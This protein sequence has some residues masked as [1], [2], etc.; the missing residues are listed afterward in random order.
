MAAGFV[1]VDEFVGIGVGI[2]ISIRRPGFMFRAQIWPRCKSI[3]RWAIA[4]PRPTP[5]LERLRSFSTR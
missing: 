2:L 5:P 3:E 1:R 4:R